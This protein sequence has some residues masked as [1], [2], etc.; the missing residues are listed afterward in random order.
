LAKASDTG[1]IYECKATWDSVNNRYNVMSAP[2]NW[3]EA[4]LNGNANN[5]S[6]YI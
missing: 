1:K 5:P 4:L 3:T 6:V 2:D